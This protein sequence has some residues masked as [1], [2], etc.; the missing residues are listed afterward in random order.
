MLILNQIPVPARRLLHDLQ[1]DLLQDGSLEDHQKDIAAT[2]EQLHRFESRKLLLDAGTATDIVRKFSAW[3][4]LRDI[5]IT[6][7][8]TPE[9]RAAMDEA[10]CEMD[11]SLY[12]LEQRRDK[13]T[14]LMSHGLLKE[15][16]QL[17]DRALQSS[18]R[19]KELLAHIMESLKAAQEEERDNLLALLKMAGGCAVVG[20]GCFYLGC[21]PK[22]WGAHHCLCH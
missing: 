1:W 18:D 6:L 15:A 5:E 7:N 16:H 21:S 20:V 19:L 9:G 8:T 14:R 2:R 11:S 4:C 3:I 13:I 17:A 10:L 12:C 22:G